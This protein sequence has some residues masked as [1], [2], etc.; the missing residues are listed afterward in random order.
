M[1]VVVALDVKPGDFFRAVYGT[2]QATP[3]SNGPDSEERFVSAVRDALNR[4]GYKKPDEGRET[5]P[6]LPD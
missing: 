6:R 2:A 1:A 5:M 3:T 4:L